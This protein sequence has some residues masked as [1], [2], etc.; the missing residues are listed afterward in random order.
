MFV[1][2]GAA[3]V[4]KLFGELWFQSR[5]TVDQSGHFS[6]TQSDPVMSHVLHG[7]LHYCLHILA[8]RVRHPAV[9]AFSFYWSSDSSEF[10]VQ[11]FSPSVC[12][13]EY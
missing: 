3:R 9:L 11:T 5:D 12:H 13:F 4:R 2:V 6:V 8:L 10:S 7:Q 1:G